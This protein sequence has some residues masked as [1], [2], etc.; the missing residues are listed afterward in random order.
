MGNRVL[1]W[2]NK[3]KSYHQNS[4]KGKRGIFG[5]L[6]AET[7]R[8]NLMENCYDFGGGND[9]TNIS[10]DTLYLQPIPRPS[11]TV[12]LVTAMTAAGHSIT[13]QRK[14]T[15]FNIFA[16]WDCSGCHYFLLITSHYG[17]MRSGDDQ[18]HNI[19]YVHDWVLDRRWKAVGSIMALTLLN[20]ECNLLFRGICKSFEGTTEY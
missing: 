18:Q 13:Y 5:S 19:W 6:K 4:T 20:I 11:N 8:Q 2:H 12:L 1:D 7:S 14:K 15:T 10:S 9:A 16:A 3:N 17:L